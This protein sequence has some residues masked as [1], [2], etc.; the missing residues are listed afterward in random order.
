MEK[1]NHAVEHNLKR[2][3]QFVPIV[4]R[5]HGENHPEFYEVKKQFDSLNKKMH[6]ENN[7]IDLNEEFKKLR[8][9]TNN[10]TVPEDVCE[11][12]EAVY[13]MLEEI[14]HAYQD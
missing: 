1:F 8:E 9:I 13:L 14:D 7:E 2:L 3:E 5:V 6:S 11:S 10:Y 12:Y 4:A